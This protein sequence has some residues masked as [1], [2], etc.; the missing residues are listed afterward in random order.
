MEDKELKQKVK[1]KVDEQSGIS[2]TVDNEGRTIITVDLF[3]EKTYDFKYNGKYTI[4]RIEV[5]HQDLW[6]RLANQS[7][8][9]VSE[10][11]IPDV[12]QEIVRQRKGQDIQVKHVLAMIQNAGVDPDGKFD[13]LSD[14]ENLMLNVKAAKGMDMLEV[15][16]NM[17]E[18]LHRLVIG[19]PD[20]L[21]LDTVEAWNGFHPGLGKELFDRCMSMLMD[22]FT[23][24][25]G[26][27]KK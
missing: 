18:V 26:L 5:R 6:A 22:N 16:G 9:A 23:I 1:E 4:A 21:E 11:D 7:K 13:D 15:Y 17:P 24:K 3:K 25:K 20:N 8:N 14:E 2:E 19:Y 27:Q 12:A 10:S